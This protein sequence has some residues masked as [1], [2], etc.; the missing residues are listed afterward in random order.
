MTLPYRPLGL[1]KDML[2]RLGI[3]MTY[4]YEDLIFL[5]HNAALLQFGQVGEILFLHTNVA[6]DAHEADQLFATLQAAASG[7]GITLLRRGHYRLTPGD[8]ETLSLEFIE[9]AD[10]S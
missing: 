10:P 4:A 8:D 3:E 2:D 7:Q 9:D 5:K 6:T 1:V